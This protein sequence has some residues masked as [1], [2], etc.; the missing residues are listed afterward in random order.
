MFNIICL[1]RQKQFQGR[2]FY[3]G[4]NTD[5]FITFCLE[6]Q[7]FIGSVVLSRVGPN[8]IYNDET[9]SCKFDKVDMNVSE[10]NFLC[11]SAEEHTIHIRNLIICLEKQPDPHPLIETNVEP[12]KSPSVL[13]RMGHASESTANGLK[14]SVVDF[15]SNNNDSSLKPC[16]DSIY[17]LK[18][19]SKEAA[20]HN[21][22]Y[23]HPCRF[24][25]MCNQLEANLTHQ[26]RQVPSM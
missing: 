25:E 8:S 26:S 7:Y 20:D 19:F 1:Y 15:F 10:L 18:Q 2:S 22:I 6:I 23:S 24:A 16:P 11:V 12:P 21:Q 9:I 14:D 13:S 4:C 5:D 17:C 3:V